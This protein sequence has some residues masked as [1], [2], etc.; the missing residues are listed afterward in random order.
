MPRTQI[1]FRLD[2]KL[3][4]AIKAKCEES[5]VSITDFLTEAARTALGIETIERTTTLSP[6][7]LE[8][9]TDRLASVELNLAECLASRE[10]IER[11]ESRVE[12]VLGELVGECSA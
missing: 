10:R 6:E 11:I 4:A 12:E 8:S 7:V 9:L 2:T 1:N 3:L 5:G